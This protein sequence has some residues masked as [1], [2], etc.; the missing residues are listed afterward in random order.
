MKIIAKVLLFILEKIV[1]N[2]LPDIVIK[3]GYMYRWYVIP[4]NRWFNI[5]F[6]L[7]EGSDEPVFHDHPWY[8]WGMLLEGSYIE[9]TPYG[10]NFYRD[11]E[12]GF[13]SPEFLHWL[14]VNNPAKTIFV[15]G[16]VLRVW[17]FLVN[18]KWVPFHEHL[19]VPK[20]HPKST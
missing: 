12:S 13:R 3:E 19:D 20:N 17:G 5:Y 14:E 10:D 11:G 7:F 15:T 2:R 8:S 9:H 16:P 6:H 18:G 1:C 4:R